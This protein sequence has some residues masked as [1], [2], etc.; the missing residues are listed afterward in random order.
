[1]LFVKQYLGFS[2]YFNLLYIIFS[3]IITVYYMYVVNMKIENNKILTIIDDF[4]DLLR[5]FL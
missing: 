5:N 3:Y 2:R 1:M 4:N